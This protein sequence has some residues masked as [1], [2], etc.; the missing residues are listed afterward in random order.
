[1][2][3]QQALFR[4]DEKIILASASPRRKDFFDGLGFDY[5][6]QT[7]SILEEARPGEDAEQFASRLALEKAEAIAMKDP[8]AWVV[9]ADTVVVFNKTLLGK[10]KDQDDAFAMMSRLN[11]NEHEV[12]TGFALICQNEKIKISKTSTS[13]VTFH[14]FDDSVLWAYVQTGE[15]MDKAG[16]YGIQGIGSFLVRRI[17][18]SCSNVIGLPVSELVTELLRNGVIS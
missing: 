11:G 13:K 7:A 4:T 14:H 12:T 5:S 10:P 6:T 8:D 3:P 1:M 9:G 16:S 15:P 18:G 17:S 2:Q